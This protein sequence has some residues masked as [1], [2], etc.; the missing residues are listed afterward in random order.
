M[1]KVLLGVALLSLAAPVL[2]GTNGGS[3]GGGVDRQSFAWTTRARTTSSTEWA[4]IE[5]L[6][7]YSGCFRQSR[8]ATAT[9]SLQLESLGPVLVR[10]RAMGLTAGPDSGTIMRPGGIAVTPERKDSFSFT[11]MLRRTPAAHGTAYIVEWR[12]PSGIEATVTKGSLRVLWD[13]RPV[14]YGCV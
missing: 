8:A 5:D 13:E 7:A 1:R 4:E 6:I 14:D 3:G 2:A 11:F 9:V 10:V 12:S